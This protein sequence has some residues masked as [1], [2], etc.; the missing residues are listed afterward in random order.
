MLRWYNIEDRPCTF[1]SF[2]NVEFEN[3]AY[4]QQAKNQ[5]Q[6]RDFKGALQKQGEGCPFLFVIKND[7]MIV[8]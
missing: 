6:S 8:N 4:A 7:Q 3:L 2:N 5:G 1:Y